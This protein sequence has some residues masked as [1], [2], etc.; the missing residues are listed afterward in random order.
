MKGILQLS[1]TIALLSLFAAAQTT[2]TDTGKESGT[3]TEIR[4]VAA[5]KTSPT[6]GAENYKAYCAA[7]HGVSGKGDGPAA[8]ALKIPPTD[9]TRLT[10]NAGG[11][12]PMMHVRADDPEC[13]QSGARQQRYAG[14]GSRLPLDEQREPTGSRPAGSKPGQVHR[15]IA[16]QVKPA[17]FQ[18]EGAPRGRLLLLRPTT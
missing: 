7:C 2:K 8:P 16:N 18:G 4:H 1:A 3:A 12:Y 15:D 11:K 9:L 13:R 5:P 6:S 10:A 17:S 14:L